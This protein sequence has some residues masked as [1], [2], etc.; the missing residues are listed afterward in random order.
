MTCWKLNKNYQIKQVVRNYSSKNIRMAIIIPTYYRQNKSSINN[1]RNL[2]TSIN[3][4]VYQDFHIF[5][6]GDDYEHPSEILELLENHDLK[7]KITF[8]NNPISFRSYNFMRKQNYW[9]I[10]GS[11]ALLYGVTRAIKEGYDYYAHIDDDDTWLP[12]H[13]LEI[14]TYI[15]KFPEGD[16]FYT[17][18]KY[19]KDHFL[20]GRLHP[21]DEINYNIYQPLPGHTCHSAH[22]YNL[23][24]L[25]IS[26]IED[27]SSQITLANK[28]DEY[29]KKS[30]IDRVFSLKKSNNIIGFNPDIDFTPA[31]LKIAL[32]LCNSYKYKSVYIPIVTCIKESDG[33]Y[34]EF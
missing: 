12:D 5:L 29:V 2:L 17:R 34:V 18:S 9:A 1:L 15:R 30:K 20:P 3:N 21:P 26:I 10:G 25:G 27:F 22:V 24:T 13:L 8:Y 14:T 33:N 31:D 7:N 23:N 19:C 11:H 32:R 16:W 6:I 4:Q 28:V